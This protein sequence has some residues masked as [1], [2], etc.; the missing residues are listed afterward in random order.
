MN[1][2]KPFCKVCQDAGKSESVYTSHFV[3]SS[4][5]PGSVVTC[6]TLLALECR[7]CHKAGHTVKYCTIL[8][9][10]KK[11][12]K[13]REKQQAQQIRQE[14]Q[15][16]A[17]INVTNKK[18][19]V[20]KNAFACLDNEESDNEQEEL[21]EPKVEEEKV[22]TY[23][24]ILSKPKPEPKQEQKLEVLV[25]TQTTPEQAQQT[26]AQQ[27]QAQQSKPEQTQAKGNWTFKMPT[28]S[29]ADWTDSE[30]EEDLIPPPKP[31]LRRQ[32]SIK[33]DEE[34]YIEFLNIPMPSEPPKLVRQFAQYGATYTTYG[35][36]ASRLIND[37]EDW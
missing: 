12:E 5:Q 6:P 33:N 31:A 8:E 21:N 24:S 18:P 17:L 19:E 37:D 22:V 2:M 34:E 32:P 29:W 35:I 36:H 23:A 28:K 10:R 25:S 13:K 3:R 14:S 20:Y 9:E 7:F 11:M 16:N 15:K 27:T 4:T 30:D 1:T 26:Q